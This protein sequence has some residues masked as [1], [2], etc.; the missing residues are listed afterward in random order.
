MAYLIEVPRFDD[1][2]GSLCVVDNLLPFEIKRTYY[3]FNVTGER[4]GHRHK[5][6]I[7]A[8]V[9]LSGKC[10]IY[11]NDGI[12]ESNFELSDPNMC[13]IIETKD[14]HTMKNFTKSATLLVMSS[15][16]YDRNDY[17][18]EKY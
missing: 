13:L 3:I 18:D 6:T 11:V 4:G 14:W 9:C 7:Q 2:R 12:S 10:D 15:E 1:E 16:P 17:I 8:L 5:K